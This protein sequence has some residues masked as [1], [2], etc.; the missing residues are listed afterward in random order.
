M[1]D[2]PSMEQNSDAWKAPTTLTNGFRAEHSGLY[3][4]SF[5]PNGLLSSVVYAPR[6]RP[7][8][9]KP[10]MIAHRPS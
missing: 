4:F 7:L 5:G 1:I 8:R 2:N 6:R 3:S 10:S 9:Y